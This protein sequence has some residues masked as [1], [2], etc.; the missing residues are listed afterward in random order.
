MTGAH[1]LLET[2]QQTGTAE[3]RSIR[4][5][6]SLTNKV[7]SKHWDSP[8]IHIELGNGTHYIKKAFTSAT[9][10]NK[11]LH[12][13]QAPA[14]DQSHY[15]G[16]YYTN[17]VWL[18][19]NWLVMEFYLNLLVLLLLV[20]EQKLTSLL[21]ILSFVIFFFKVCSFL[22]VQSGWYQCIQI[23]QCTFENLI[24]YSSSPKYKQRN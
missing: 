8:T 22:A 23:S 21:P 12:P 24:M 13:Y 15:N 10:T 1:I 20:I 2:S 17:K 5:C 14:K 9:Q 6:Q 3:L 7:V 16:V 19:D 11:V 4:K 18:I